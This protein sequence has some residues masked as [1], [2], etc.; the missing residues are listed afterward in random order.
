[1]GTLTVRKNF[2]FDKEL[3][4]NVGVILKEKNK[5]FTKLLTDYF[6]A[7]TKNPELIEDIE[8]KAQKRNASFIGILDGKIG[9]MD[10]KEM[11]KE[12]HEHIS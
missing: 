2:V 4:D 7:I 5:N 1:M 9:D 8:E 12:Y 3:V 6:K 10:Y 11:R